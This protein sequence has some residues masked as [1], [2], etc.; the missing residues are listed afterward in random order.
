MGN[1]EVLRLVGYRKVKRRIL[2]LCNCA[3]QSSEQTRVG[4]YVFF[5]KPG[6][7]ALEDRP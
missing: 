1:A 6:P 5:L 3:R 2:A 4:D 7:Y